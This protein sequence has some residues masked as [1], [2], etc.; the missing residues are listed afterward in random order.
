MDEL[1]FFRAVCKARILNRETWG[2][3]ISKKPRELTANVPNILMAYIDSGKYNI[4]GL[5][6][7]LLLS[8]DM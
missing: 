1:L 2:K 3:F 4:Y 5:Q 7:G 6:N 8:P